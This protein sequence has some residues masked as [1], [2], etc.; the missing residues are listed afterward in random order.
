M[1]LLFIDGNLKCGVEVTF[2]CMRFLYHVYQSTGSTEQ[3]TGHTD[4]METQV[5]NGCV[6]GR[7]RGLKYTI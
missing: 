3:V 1:L 2:K 6:A 4:S 5:A 7:G